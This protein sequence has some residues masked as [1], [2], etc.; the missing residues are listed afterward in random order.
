LTIIGYADVRGPEKYNHLLSERRA[1][2]AKDYLVSKGVPAAELKVEAKG[3]DDQI[4]LG[5]VESLQAR[6]S[7]KPDKWMNKKNKATWLAYNRRVDIVLEPTGQQSTKLYPNDIASAHLLWQRP[8]PSLR[9]ISKF[10]RNSSGNERASL[11]M[12]GN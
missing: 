12:H 4:A 10:E 9:A 1:E 5:T 3:K 11:T 7:Q 2:L 8:E 6:D